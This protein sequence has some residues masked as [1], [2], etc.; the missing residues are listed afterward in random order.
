MLLLLLP[1]EYG[2]GFTRPCGHV[3]AWDILN[4]KKFCQWIFF[5]S[6]IS[7]AV[8]DFSVN[9]VDMTS[10]GCDEAF[11][12]PVFAPWAGAIRRRMN[13]KS[14]IERPKYQRKF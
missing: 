2:I 13:I 9:L 7:N 14:E 8:S 12:G 11:S 6:L 3:W 1:C 4:T 10:A 5:Q